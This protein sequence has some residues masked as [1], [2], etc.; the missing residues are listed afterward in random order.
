LVIEKYERLFERM[1][2]LLMT[3]AMELIEIKNS[4][5]MGNEN[6]GQRGRDS[7]KR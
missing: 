1:R 5:L 4:V 7:K 6:F 2:N 3:G